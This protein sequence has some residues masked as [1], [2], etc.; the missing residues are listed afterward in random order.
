MLS[1]PLWRHRNG[2]GFCQF[3]RKFGEEFIHILLWSPGKSYLCSYM[4]WF[5]SSVLCF[6]LEGGCLLRWN[7]RKVRQNKIAI[8]FRLN[9]FVYFRVI[10][11]KRKWSTNLFAFAILCHYVSQETISMVDCILISACY[12][13]IVPSICHGQKIDTVMSLTRWIDYQIMSHTDPDRKVHGANMG[14]IWGRQDPGGPHVGPWTSLS[15]MVIVIL[16]T[17][18]WIVLVNG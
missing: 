10:H 13:E 12:N 5:S 14:S 1:Y 8:L 9:R 2:S 6:L 11:A 3:C 4:L 17:R 16:L 18:H 15:G 7:S